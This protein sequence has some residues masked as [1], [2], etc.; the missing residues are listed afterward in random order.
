VSIGPILLHAGEE[1]TYC[2]TVRLPN[3]LDSN[4]IEIHSELAPGS[5]HL[6]LYRSSETTESL[7]PTPCKS[8][9]GITTG[10]VPIFIAETLATTLALPKDVA[11]HFVPGEMVRIEA[12]YINATQNDIMG[13][14]KVTLTPGTG[15]ATYQQADIMFCGSIKQLRAHGVPANTQNYTLDP[16]FYG[17]GNDIDLTKLKIFAFT[18]HEHRLGSNVTIA[19]STSA[20]DPGTQLYENKSWDQPPLQAFDDNHLLTFQPGEGLRWQCS[21]DSLDA[22][23]PPTMTTPFGL[24]AVSNEMCFIWAYYYPSAGRFIGTG[25]C[26]Q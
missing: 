5:H 16:G 21:Y 17:G 2:S 6:V 12:H 3:K 20:S 15:G 19:K 22:S 8:F 23:P 18:S 4:V 14:G 13:Q 24:S 9:E 25:D 1:N 11:Y 7:T 10:I 26:V